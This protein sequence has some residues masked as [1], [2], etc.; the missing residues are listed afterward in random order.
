VSAGVHAAY[1]VGSFVFGLL[2]GGGLSVVVDRTPQPEPELEMDTATAAVAA[3]EAAPLTRPRKGRRMAAVMAVTGV[4]F[5]L[6]FI[7]FGLE[8][9]LALAWFFVAVLVAVAFIDWELFIIPNEI[10]L[11][12]VPIGLAAAIALQPDHWWVYLVAAVGG[13]AFLFILALIW[14]GGMGAGDMKLA[15]FMGAVLGSLTILAMFLAFFLGAV[16]G[17]ILMASKRKTRKDHIPFGPYLA[18]GSVIA[19]LYGPY[20]TDAYLRLMH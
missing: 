3:V 18:A 9:K 10:V 17:L 1:A 7:Q 4:A 6:A 15:L 5:L 12:A 11:P 20:L 13:A 14:P 19:L 2:A 8:W 16:A